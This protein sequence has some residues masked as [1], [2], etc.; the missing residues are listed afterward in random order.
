MVE[1]NSNVRPVNNSLD[2]VNVT[3]DIT[4]HGVIDMVSNMPFCFDIG[5]YFIIPVR[6]YTARLFIF[7]SRSRATRNYLEESTETLRL[8][9]RFVCSVF[10]FV[11]R[12]QNTFQLQFNFPKI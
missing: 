6:A 11:L 4:F 7:K 12:V 9:V 10:G 1:G 3:L 5:H 8:P 2:P